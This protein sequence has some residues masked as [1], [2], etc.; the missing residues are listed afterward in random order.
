MER[1]NKEIS[2]SAMSHCNATLRNG[3]TRARS[4]GSSSAK[5][6]GFAAGIDSAGRLR[7]FRP[8]AE[9][10]S[11]TPGEADIGFKWIRVCRMADASPRL[12]QRRRPQRKLLF[13]SPRFTAGRTWTGVERERAIA[14]GPAA[15]S[16][17][18][19]AN[20]PRGRDAKPRGQPQRKRGLS[21]RLPKG[22]QTSVV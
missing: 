19:K 6:A 11:L 1:L 13:S 4:P 3:I 20:R 5:R 21:A 8:S 18:R 7:A 22:C 12:M 16:S 14:R 15:S 2:R 10:I 9:Q 17:S